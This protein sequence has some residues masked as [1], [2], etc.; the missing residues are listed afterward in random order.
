MTNEN[1]YQRWIALGLLL[2]IMLLIVF[3]AI[4][5]LISSGMEYYSETKDLKFRLHRHQQIIA[6]KDAVDLGIERIKQQY[7]TQKYF[8]TSD[9]VSL[10]SANIQKLLKNAIV[11]AGGELT[12]SQV[13]PSRAEDG[14]NKITVKV[15]MSGDM[16][17]L[18]NVL[19]DIENAR[20]VMIINQIDIRPV[21]GR[22]NRKTRKIE[23]SNKLNVNFEVVGFM[24][25]RAA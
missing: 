21:R 19:Y 14:F 5:P 3:F 20:P 25:E 22:R 15:R 23:P 1:S 9:T 8:N 2:V 24:R 17:A 18:R 13:L 6:R 11:Q 4:A 10:A 7:T 12:S 16:E